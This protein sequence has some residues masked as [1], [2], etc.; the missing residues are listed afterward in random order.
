M[1]PHQHAVPPV[2]ILSPRD[3]VEW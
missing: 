3:V 1:K 2:L